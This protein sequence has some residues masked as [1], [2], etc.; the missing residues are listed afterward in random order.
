MRRLFLAALLAC[1]ALAHASEW[2][3]FS[4][5]FTSRWKTVGPHGH[6]QPYCAEHPTLT[7]FPN[8]AI[9]AEVPSCNPADFAR[10]NLDDSIGFRAGRERDVLA[11]GP[12]RLV[13]GAEA[14]VSYTEY[15]ITQNDVALLSGAL[16]AGADLTVRG[17]RIGARYGAGPFV[18]TD[19]QELGILR[20]AETTITL[21]LR[22]GAAV[23]ISRRDSDALR[24]WGE[25]ASPEE[26]RRSP[27]AR[28][29]S[30]L[31]VAS[32]E[33]RGSSLWE[34]GTATGT[35]APGLGVGSARSLRHTAFTR[36]NA[37]RQ[38]QWHD[39]Q[40]D[41]SWSSTA[42]ES[43]LPSTF[44]GYD[45]NFR[46]KTINGFG[47][48]AAR[49][50]ALFGRGTLRYGG[51]IEL[52]DWRDEHKLLTRNGEELVA[53]VEVG[54]TA[55]VAARF[56]LGPHL[57]FESLLQKVYW[58]QLDLGEARLAFGLTLTR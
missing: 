40:L 46:S 11:L 52:A 28:E 56:P 3:T 45:N 49:S 37:S 10:G 53:G 54:V 58:P 29:I 39:L 6:D 33:T 4:G 24:R 41:L 35:T 15:N 21:P 19:A 9:L 16:A 43:A 1:A 42:H 17:V 30:V 38:L 23:R 26:N 55:S 12:L 20:Y 34:F 32:P 18:T 22:N 2:R 13:G 14:S 47:I 8:G 51:G 44:R 31:L 25:V 48:G 36:A 27:A 5:G 50:R 7:Y 57:A